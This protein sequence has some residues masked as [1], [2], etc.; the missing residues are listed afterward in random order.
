MSVPYPKKERGGV[1]PVGRVGLHIYRDPPS[2]K[3]TRKYEPVNIKEVMYMADP[4]SE[5]G[6]PS[7][8]NES[9]LYYARGK[10]PMVEIDYG[11]GQG[12]SNPYKVE[13]VRPPLEPFQTKNA[14][15]R[16]DVH[17]NYAIQTN[18]FI[19]PVSIGNKIDR[20]EIAKPIHQ[21]QLAG[22]IKATPSVSYYN[23]IDQMSRDASTKIRSDETILR[24]S[25]RP[26]SSYDLNP[27]RDTNFIRS[28]AVGESN[29]YTVTSNL[30]FN[31]QTPNAAEMRE[32]I[33]QHAIQDLNTFGVTSN[34]TFGNIV[35]FDPKTNAT[36]DLSSTVKD[37]HYI[38][39]NAAYGKPLV[40]N[41]NDGRQIMLKDYSYS[42]V[43]TAVG[44]PQ[45][46]IQVNQPD[47]HLDRNTPLFTASS[48]L[49]GLGETDAARMG[50][51]SIELEQNVPLVS[52][53]SGISQSNSA[54]GVNNARTTQ[55]NWHLNKQATFGEFNRYG[56]TDPNMRQDYRADLSKKERFN[57]T[58]KLGHQMNLE[59]A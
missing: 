59:R 57:N 29:V 31:R 25:I 6:D 20:N 26:T 36:L 30:N 7:R 24:G 21:D 55:E 40:F 10:N 19:E 42:A 15:T 28:T 47:V 44:N 58:A 54:A 56:K 5:H 41:T 35:V 13:V 33:S 53:N 38:A 52:V 14:I 51:G 3:F 50:A 9:I 34:A 4:T 48:N 23:L 39:V 16:P 45:L 8:M 46:I 2:A 49:R 22:V 17:Q 43:N 12:A 11:A 1:N 27:S 32:S 18:P 37:K